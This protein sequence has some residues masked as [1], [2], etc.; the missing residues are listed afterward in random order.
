MYNIGVIGNGFV[1]GAVAHGLSAAST[2]F[3]N[4][5]IYDNDPAK[6]IDTLSDVVNKSDFVFISVDVDVDKIFKRVI[7]TS[8]AHPLVCAP[9]KNTWIKNLFTVSFSSS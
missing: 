3:C 2:G 1:G 4:E 9:Y 7:E 5:R 8:K 6:T